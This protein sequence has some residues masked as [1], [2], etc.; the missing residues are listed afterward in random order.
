M[1]ARELKHMA[2]LTEWKERVSACRSSGMTV[3]AWCEEQGIANKTYYYWEKEVLAEAGR[4]MSKSESGKE[5]RFV[6]MP[7]LPERSTQADNDVAQAQEVKPA[8]AAKLWIK[9]EALEI[10]AGA[11]E[12]MLEALVRILKDAE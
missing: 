12:G 9:G 3:R 7:A 5:K 4:Q 2:Q 11:D 1:N 6:E 8:L 10:Y